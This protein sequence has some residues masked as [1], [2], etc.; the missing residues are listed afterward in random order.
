MSFSKH[1]FDWNQL[2]S[3]D[4]GERINCLKKRAEELSS[5]DTFSLEDPAMLPDI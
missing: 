5:G 4:L 2:D 3:L 1:P